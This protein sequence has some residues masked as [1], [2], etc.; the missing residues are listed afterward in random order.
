MKRIEV[1]VQEA[2]QS[3]HNRSGQKW[4]HRRLS[5]GTRKTYTPHTTVS[6]SFPGGEL[7]RIPAEKLRD[8]S[9]G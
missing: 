1:L 2:C 5:A 9:P 6:V 7:L 4:Y 3:E 8:Y